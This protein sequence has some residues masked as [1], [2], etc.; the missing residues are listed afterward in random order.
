VVFGDRTLRAYVLL[1]WAGCAFVFAPEGLLLSLAGQYG[2][3][4]RIGG[5]L[6]AA[7]PLGGA[8]GAVVLTRLTGPARRASLILPLAL[9]SCAALIPIAFAPPLWIV[10]ALLAVA[11]FGNA[12][13]VPLNPMFGRAIPNS[14]RARAF[15]VAMGGLCALQGLAMAAAGL[16]AERLSPT[17][18]TAACGIAGTLAVGALAA[19]WP[20]T[21][22][23]AAPRPAE[24][25]YS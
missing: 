22:T 16:L 4:A 23:P 20:R 18:V 21:S 10:L 14:Y 13:C 8:I 1:L 6:L 12:Y 19:R 15:G 2:G 25:A 5:L 24:P 3:D 7:A 17:T 9:V 11:G